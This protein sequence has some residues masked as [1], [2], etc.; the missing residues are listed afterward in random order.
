MRIGFACK[1]IPDTDDKKVYRDHN[2]ATT[3]IKWLTENGAK[4]NDRLFDI[5]KH[6]VWA[7]KRVL[8]IVATWPE[9][10]RMMRIGSDF[11]PV[12]THADFKWFWQQKH[13]QEFLSSQLPAIGDFARQ[14]GIRLS[15]HPGQFTVLN[16]TNDDTV[17]SSI[18]EIEYHTDIARY[19]GYVLRH[20]DGFAINVHVGSRAGGVERFRENAQLLSEDAR[21]FLTIENDEMSFGIDDVLELADEFAIVLDIHHHWCFTEG[22]FI[23]ADD[24]RIERIIDSWHGV[25]PKIHYSLSREDYIPS[26]GLPVYADL[27]AP[28]TKLRAHSD[29]CHNPDLNA[30]AATHLQWADVMVEAKAKNLASHQFWTANSIGRVAD[31]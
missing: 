4:Q 18:E 8:K 17:I 24:S 11:F 28:K 25:R 3:T 1:F 12:Y 10:L 6:N 14:C 5:L 7:F 23:Q 26:K 21:N 9:P 20:Q 19:L 13:V 29:M 27:S 30:W 31:S 2:L 15:M 16:S 22:E